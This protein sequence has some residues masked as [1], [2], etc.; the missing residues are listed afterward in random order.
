MPCSVSAFLGSMFMYFVLTNNIDLHQNL[1]FMMLLIFFIIIVFGV[2]L[3]SIIDKLFKEK[4]EDV[5]IGDN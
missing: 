4:N 3:G 1:A 2:F 5:F